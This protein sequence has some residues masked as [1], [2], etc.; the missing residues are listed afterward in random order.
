M[1]DIY[2]AG[3]VYA[4]SVPIDD[5]QASEDTV[6]SSAKVE[7]MVDEKIENIKT[8]PVKS[9]TIS[10]GATI[11]A[12]SWVLV[13]DTDLA[14]KNFQGVGVNSV[15]AYNVYYTSAF[16]DNEGF[17]MILINKGTSQVTTGPITCYYK[18]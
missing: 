18:D 6:Y 16:I 12:N 17:K 1:G 5:T 7:T 3:E 2:H 14:G 15:A 4:G 8:A 9:K 11:G 10:N 13:S